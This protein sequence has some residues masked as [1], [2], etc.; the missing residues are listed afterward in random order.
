VGWDEESDD[1]AA[2]T[3]VA[4]GSTTLQP[5]PTLKG[6]DDGLLK[7]SI[8]SPRSHDVLSQPDSDASYDI[9]SGAPSRAG[10]SP[11]ESKIDEHSDEE[12]WE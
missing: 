10:G 7:P 8:V 5:K 2:N 12:D 1:E 4:G 3:P 9:V 6:G 11:K